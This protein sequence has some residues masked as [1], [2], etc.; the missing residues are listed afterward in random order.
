MIGASEYALSLLDLLC[1]QAK[2]FISGGIPPKYSSMKEYLCY[3][4]VPLLAKR[5]IVWLPSNERDFN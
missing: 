1:E 3:I 5:E 4:L 2:R